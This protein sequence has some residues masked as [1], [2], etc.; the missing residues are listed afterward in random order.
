M[1]RLAVLGGGRMGEALV[2]GLLARGWDPED[3]AER[4]DGLLAQPELRAQMGA[5]AHARAAGY[6][7]SMAAAR[8]RRLYGDL[9][10]RALVQCS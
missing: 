9:T 3:Y 2:L 1:A 5:S 8:L 10:V 6:A 4:V 7:W